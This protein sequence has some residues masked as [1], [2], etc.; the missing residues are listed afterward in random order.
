MK[1]YIVHSVP[2]NLIVLVFF[3]F[4]ICSCTDHN[5]EEKYVGSILE[6]Y[7]NG[8]PKLKGQFKDSLKDGEFLYYSEKGMLMKKVNYLDDQV[9]GE[10]VE[11]YKNG[12]IRRKSRYING[13]KR[14]KEFY[15]YPD[16]SIWR[17]KEFIK[18]YMDSSKLNTWKVYDRA[19]KVKKDSSCYFKI[20]NKDTIFQKDHYHTL[21]VMFPTTFHSRNISF[22]EL[23][24]MKKHISF[25]DPENELAQFCK[26]TTCEIELKTGS[27]GPKNL[28]GVFL[29]YY[30]DENGYYSINTIYIDY[31]YIVK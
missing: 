5:E 7:E 6:F 1:Q 9:D 14:G 11:Y 8:H 19:G 15:Y 30:L 29:D 27:K 22:S 20:L 4:L 26:T 21:Q 3:H 28:K 10:I 2:N 17:K 24:F 23:D 31:S 16:G 25:I 18:T 13:F 12:I